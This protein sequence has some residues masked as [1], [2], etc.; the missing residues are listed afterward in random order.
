[1][2]PLAV[3]Y[4]QI[5]VGYLVYQITPYMK[6]LI[7]CLLYPFH[8]RYYVIVG[9]KENNRKFVRL[10][11]NETQTLTS[12]HVN[13]RDIPTGYF[14]SSKTIG[15]LDNMSEYESENKIHILTTTS[16]Y[17]QIME[18]NV[19]QINTPRSIDDESAELLPSN[20]MREQ[21]KIQ[22]YIRVGTYK[23]FYYRSLSLDVSHIDPI[24]DQKEV[25]A[26]IVKLYKEK[27]RAS[28]FIHGVTLAGKSSVGYLVAKAIKG[29]FCHTFNPTEPGD[30]FSSMISEITD[31]DEEIPLVITLEEAN[32]MIRAVH[33][34]T[35]LQVPDMP[36]PVRDKTT[37]VNM[38]DDLIFY[39]NVVLILTSNESKVAIDRLDP[40]YLRKGRIDASYAM[41]NKLPLDDGAP[42]AESGSTVATDRS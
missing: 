38:M 30:Q 27:G 25:V 28:V 2:V 33:T 14:I 20:I 12:K 15:Y 22:V 36:T 9:D 23:N 39:K 32:E 19:V 7:L 42:D 16:F 41:L 26:G 3:N 13:G 5:A 1:M 37:W 8:I 21:E 29:R 35:T 34:K 31:R 11:E 4:W 6:E 18:K 40:A 10:I 17:K 24:G